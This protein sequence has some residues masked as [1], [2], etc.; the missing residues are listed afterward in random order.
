MLASCNNDE[1]VDMPASKNAIS[2]KSFVNKSTRATDLTNENITDFSVFGFMENASG[3]I[4][5]NE[6]VTG[7]GT[8][9]AADWTYANTQYWTPEKHYYFSAIAPATGGK[10]EFDPLTGDATGQGGTISFTNDGHQDLLYAYKD[11]QAPQTITATDPAPVPLTF[12]HLLS[13]VK[14]KFTNMMGNNNAKLKIT[15]VRIT[16]ANTKA[17][18][19]VDPAQMTWALAGDNATAEFNFGAIGNEIT[20]TLSGETNHMYLI[21]QNQTYTLEFAVELW[22]GDVLAYT[23]YHTDDKAVTIPAINMEPGHSYVFCA[24]LNG[25]TINPDE[26]LYPIVFTVDEVKDWEDWENGNEGNLLPTH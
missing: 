11:V 18:I 22:Q 2:F 1:H 13:R 20:Y 10:W 19:N 21:P 5:N 16:D 15:S 7:S 4:F 26:A 25:Q 12:N 23:Y 8:G 3:A 14:F 24:E 9:A 6:T 17:T